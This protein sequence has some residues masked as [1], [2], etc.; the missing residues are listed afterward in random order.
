MK[1]PNF[2]G[3]YKIESR[4]RGC[5]YYG[6]AKDIHNRWRGHRRDLRQGLH[7]SRYMQSL[8]NKYGMDD[9]V[10]SVCEQCSAEKLI[11]TEQKYLDCVF[12][13]P[14]KMRMNSA[15][16]AGTTLGFKHR[17]AT[18]ERLKKVRQNISPEWRKNLSNAWHG[19]SEESKDRIYAGFKTAEYV[20][21]F[22]KR[23]AE[24]NKINRQKNQTW[25]A[26]KEF[27]AEMLVKSRMRGKEGDKKQSDFMKARFAGMSPLEK[28]TALGVK[29]RLITMTHAEKGTH[30]MT[31]LEFVDKYPELKK[32]SIHNML[33]GNTKQSNGWRISK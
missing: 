13:L 1:Q 24:M 22:R 5:I 14:K 11:E 7:H 28:Y 6:S 8:F 2:S 16:I 33:Q 4:S 26:S 21:S 17:P 9:L 32:S 23:S 12:S 27:K 19:M 30:T 25:W 18:I 31:K 20:E 29:P 3:I 10:F 15:R